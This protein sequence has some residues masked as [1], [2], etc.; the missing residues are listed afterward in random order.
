MSQQA[1]PW[2]RFWRDERGVSATEFTLT[3]PLLLML[4]MGSVAV[5]D[6]FRTSQRVEKATFTIGDVISRQTVMS[7][8]FLDQTFAIFLRLVSSTPAQS[9]LR[10]SSIIRNDDEYSIQWTETRGNAGALSGRPVPVDQIPVIANGDSVV[11]TETFLP[12]RS[13]LAA[14]GAGDIVYENVASYRPRFVGAIAKTN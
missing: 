12:H 11:L 7:E 8:S 2:G 14:V 9:A 13:F 10:V 1:T 5:F 6:L 3:V 4:I